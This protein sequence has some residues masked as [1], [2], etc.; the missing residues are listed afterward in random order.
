MENEKRGG[1][2]GGGGKKDMWQHTGTVYFPV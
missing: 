2:G 1:G